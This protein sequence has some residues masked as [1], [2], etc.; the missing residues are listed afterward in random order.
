MPFN[1]LLQVYELFYY[2][3]CFMGLV[4]ERSFL[5]W[6]SSGVHSMTDEALGTHNQ[7]RKQM[8]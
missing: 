1:L 2:N 4:S 8:C 6:W 5:V 3:I 7:K